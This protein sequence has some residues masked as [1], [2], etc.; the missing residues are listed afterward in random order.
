MRRSLVLCLLLALALAACGDATPSATSAPAEATLA[1]TAEPTAAPT[2]T[3]TLPTEETPAEPTAVEAAP[4]DTALPQ[5]TEA[6]AAPRFSA[7]VLPILQA[8]CGSCHGRSGGL[9]VTSVADLLA[10]GNGGP[11]IV[12]GDGVASL[13]V[14]RI[15][16]E[17]NPRMP[18]GGDALPAEQIETIMAWIDAGALDD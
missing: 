15:N 7:D 14:R 16:G 5:P 3:V 17:V 2:D 8:N 6:A 1:P 4:T 18:L 11:A 10:G 12:A 13:L 9:A